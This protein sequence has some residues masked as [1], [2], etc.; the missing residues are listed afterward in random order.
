MSIAEK[1]QAAFFPS[2]STRKISMAQ[3]TGATIVLI[4]DNS[5]YESQMLEAMSQNTGMLRNT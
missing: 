5:H 4:Q 1:S 3:N 2:L